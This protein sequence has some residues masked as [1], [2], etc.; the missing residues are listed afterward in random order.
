MGE[1]QELGF[2]HA[3]F[4]MSIQ[5]PNRNVKQSVGIMSL[6]F[7]REVWAKDTNLRV[8]STWIEFKALR[9]CEII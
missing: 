2:E 8:L 3:E 1:D 7:G 9:L 5:H 6:E 4:E